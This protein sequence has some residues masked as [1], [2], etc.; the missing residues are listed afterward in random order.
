[1]KNI[2]LADGNASKARSHGAPIATKKRLYVPGTPDMS[3]WDII[4]TPEKNV[5]EE[6][7]ASSSNSNST[8]E[9]NHLSELEVSV[10][11]F[12]SKCE[13]IN[14]FIQVPSWRI[15]QYTSCYSMEGTEN[16]DDEVFLKRHQRLELDEKRR[17]RY[18]INCE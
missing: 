17:K 10:C 3:L 11:K 18:I 8:P 13:S 16:L 9:T 4:N 6:K 14:I 12:K 7:V 15:K 1:L 2:F 5:K